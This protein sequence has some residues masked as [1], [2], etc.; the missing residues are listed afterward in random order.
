MACVHPREDKNVLLYLSSHHKSKTAVSP[1]T[2]GS[3]SLQVDIRYLSEC[4]IFWVAQLGV[5]RYAGLPRLLVALGFFSSLG[6]GCKQYGSL[7]VG[8]RW[9]PLSEVLLLHS[10]SPGTFC[11]YANVGQVGAFGPRKVTTAEQLFFMGLQPTVWLWLEWVRKSCAPLLQNLGLHAVCP[12]AGVWDVPA[13]TPQRL[14][15]SM[16]A[17]FSWRG[18]AVRWESAW[19]RRPAPVGCRAPTW[20]T[21]Q[22]SI[23]AWEAPQAG[24]SQLQLSPTFFR[25]EAKTALTTHPCLPHG[26]LGWFSIG[27]GLQME[28]VDCQRGVWCSSD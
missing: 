17:H 4:K 15:A 14:K 19:I 1:T 3:Y 27:R 6:T 26:I 13:K 18:L 10:E 8:S 22:Q 12:R 16:S 24:A 20:T 5:A 11:N 2:G 7:E 25:V 21:W 23:A 9:A 28:K